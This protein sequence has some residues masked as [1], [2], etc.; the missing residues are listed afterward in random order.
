MAP[1]IITEQNPQAVEQAV[2]ALKAGKVIAIAT[3]T[4]YGLAVDASNPQ[5]IEELYL[6]KQRDPK[7]PIAVFLSKIDQAHEIFEFDEKAQKISRKFLPGALTLVLKQKLE[8]DKIAKNLNF[9][10]DQFLGFRIVDRQFIAQL[11]EKFGGILAVTSANPAGLDAANNAQEVADYFAN[12][13]LSLIVDGGTLHTKIASTVIKV[14]NQ[15][16]EI[17]RHGAISESVIRSIL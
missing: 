6:L 10:A 15:N 8:T 11:L 13:N 17:L 2:K 16:I 5:A 3:D 12:S 14:F 7:K 4:V 1:T 9:A